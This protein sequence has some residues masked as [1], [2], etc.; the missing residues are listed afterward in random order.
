MPDNLCVP[1]S[2]AHRTLCVCSFRLQSETQQLPTHRDTHHGASDVRTKYTTPVRIFVRSAR[3]HCWCRRGGI[4]TR[5]DA[6]FRTH[7]FRG[8]LFWFLWTSRYDAVCANAL[9]FALQP[10][11]RRLR[12]ACTLG[13]PAALPRLHGT[14]MKHIRGAHRVS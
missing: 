7:K 3:S 13:C 10:A 4:S 5:T 6:K 8:M 9:E 12:S 11:Q 2:G 14:S 1:V